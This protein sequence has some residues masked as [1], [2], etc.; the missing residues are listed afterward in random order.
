[1]IIIALPN[2]K[3]GFSKA[4]LVRHRT[5]RSSRLGKLTTLIDGGPRRYALVRSGQRVHHR[6]ERLFGVI[7]LAGDTPHREASEHARHSDHIAID[8]SSCVTALPRS[9]LLSTGWHHDVAPLRRQLSRHGRATLSAG[10]GHL[11]FLRR[12]ASRQSS[13]P[14]G[15]PSTSRWRS[16]DVSRSPPSSAMSPSPTCCAICLHADFPTPMEANREDRS[17]HRARAAP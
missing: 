1:M 16:A 15:P 7:G 10:S 13:T 14:R 4:T 12:A 6:F 9:A 2:D 5:G 3:A 8:G 17:Q 11:I